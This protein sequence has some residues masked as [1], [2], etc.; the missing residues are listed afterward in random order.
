[1]LTTLQTLQRPPLPEG[2][3]PSPPADVRPRSPTRV[4]VPEEVYWETY[5][6]QSDTIYEWNNGYLEEKPVSDYNTL[7]MY[8]WFVQLLDQFLFTH[9]I[10]TTTMLEMGFRLVLPHKR[11]IRRPD[12]GVIRHDNPTLVHGDDHSYKGLCDLCVEALS[13]TDKKGIERDT[14]TKFSEYEMGGVTEYYIL[15]SKGEPMEFYRLNSQGVYVPIQPVGDVI[16]SSVLPG[17]QFRKLDLFNRPTPQEMS[18]DKVY[19]DFVLPFYQKEKRARQLA[20][21]QALEERRSRQLA[22]AQLFEE[23]Q[24]RQTLE[25]RLK[26]LEAELAKTQN[27]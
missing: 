24:T 4:W 25:M 27:L 15:Y 9:P 1:M 23:Q 5:Y 19:Q 26:Q 14:V 10:A 18:E 8:K 16:K 13:D 3:H 22:E 11:T 6:P 12:L 17:F 7:L 2:R 21:A 20:E